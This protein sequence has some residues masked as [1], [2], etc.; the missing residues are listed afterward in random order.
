MDIDGVGLVA[1]WARL[2]LSLG[3]SDIYQMLLFN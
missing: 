1:A 2:A 3:A